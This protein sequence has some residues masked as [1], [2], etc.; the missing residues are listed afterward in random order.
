MPLH[1]DYDQEKIRWF[2]SRWI[3]KKQWFE[4]HGYSPVSTDIHI[5]EKD[6]SESS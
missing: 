2:C 1:G 6:V 3:D 5:D 4:I